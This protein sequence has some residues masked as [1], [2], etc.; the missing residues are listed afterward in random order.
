LKPEDHAHLKSGKFDR[1]AWA[2]L[3]DRLPEKAR[4]SVL[5]FVL[6]ELH[7]IESGG[8]FSIRW[9]FETSEQREETGAQVYENDQPGDV[10]T[11]CGRVRI[12]YR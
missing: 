3:W 11:F 2:E 8:M 1:E 6:H 9:N 5:Q 4:S 10:I 7:A 12:G